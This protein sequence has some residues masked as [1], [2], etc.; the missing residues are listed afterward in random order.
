[1]NEPIAVSQTA[2]TIAGI[3]NAMDLTEDDKVICLFAAL[4]LFALSL[5]RPGKPPLELLRE[6]IREG[7]ETP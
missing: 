6:L 7:G 1:M 5:E 3:L 2:A 4:E